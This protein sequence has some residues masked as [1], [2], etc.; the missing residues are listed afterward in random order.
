VAVEEKER[1]G[2]GRKE[3]EE[4]R[5]EEEEEEKE[6]EETHLR[7]DD[8]CKEVC[9]QLREGFQRRLPFVKV[10]LHRKGDGEDRAKRKDGKGRAEAEVQESGRTGKCGQDGCCAAAATK[11][12][13]SA[14]RAESQDRCD[15]RGGWGGQTN[16]QRAKG[17]GQRGK[18]KR[19]KCRH[20]HLGGT[21]TR[22][23]D[24]SVRL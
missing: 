17:K 14:T 2:G 12:K 16:L 9:L 6:E 10:C 23:H 24:G 8:D 7:S 21:P 3:E 13:G 20:L 5:E 11:E 22:D 4:K 18:G 19:V 15:V 1:G